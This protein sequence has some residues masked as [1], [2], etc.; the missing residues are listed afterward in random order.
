MPGNVID[1]SRRLGA[2]T[3]GKTPAPGRRAVVAWDMGLSLGVSKGGLLGSLI[4]GIEALTSR[5]W[6]II[7]VRGKIPLVSCHQATAA[8]AAVVGMIRSHPG[9]TGIAVATGEIS[10]VLVVDVDPRGGGAAS[11]RRLTDT[12]GD[13]PTGPL[14]VTGSGGWHLYY[15][16]TPGLTN[17]VG[18]IG[19]GVD[20]RTTGG[21]AIVPPSRHPNGRPYLW[22]SDRGP[23]LE[24]PEAPEW[25]IRKA[26]GRSPDPTPPRRLTTADLPLAVE[27]ARRWLS[28]IDPAIQG[29]GGDNRT[30]FV[31]CRL[32]IGFALAD[33]DALAL[34]REWNQRCVPPW[35][36][37]DLER[38]LRNARKYGKGAWGSM[39]C[40]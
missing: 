35:D 8:A 20:I 7:P 32:V 1:K 18:R 22:E 38:K 10:G 36:E 37:R 14:A 24:L 19:A 6:A 13:L 15:R 25:L 29:Q 31:A 12:Y 23:E 40:K 5:G 3:P 17:S 16:H 9:A 30:F 33:G 2:P 11:M 4:R 39:L 26:R 28:R 27:L 34:M 21:I